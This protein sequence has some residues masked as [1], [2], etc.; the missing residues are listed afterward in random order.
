LSSLSLA[1][2]RRQA[3][4]QIRRNVMN[5]PGPSAMAIPGY[6]LGEQI[7]VGGFQSEFAFSVWGEE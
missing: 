1:E 6:G 7:F 3:A 5:H 2:E 4:A